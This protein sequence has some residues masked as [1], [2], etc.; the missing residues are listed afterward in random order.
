MKRSFRGQL[1]TRFA[2]AMVVAASAAALVGYLAL[3]AVLN[4]QIDASLLSVA[5]IQ[6]VS[7]TDDPTGQMRFQEWDLTPE[8]AESLRDLNRYAQVWN[9]SGVSLLR[10]RYMVS[11]LP[12]DHEL[13]AAASEGPVWREDEYEGQPIRA[14]YY[15]LS[16]QGAPHIEHVLEVAAPLAARDRTLQLV[17]YFLA[18]VV[19]IVGGGT[20]VGSWWL[21][22]STVRP[23]HEIIDQTEAIGAGT[24]GHHISAHADIREYERLVGVL[25]TMLDRIDEAFETQR[26]FTTDA[27]HELRS[28]LT[29]LRGELELALRR[30][31]SPDEYRRVLDSALEEAERLSDMA[32]NLLTLARSDAGAI[33]PR[34][35]QVDLCERVASVVERLQPRA[36]ARD[37]ALTVASEGPLR[38]VGDGALL[39]RLAWNLTDNA[40]KFAPPGG[41]VEVALTT[42]NGNAVITVSDDGPGI[43]PEDLQRVFERFYRSPESVD[44]G[45]SGLGLAIVRAI[46]RAHG[47]QARVENLA[48]GGAAFTVLLPRSGPQ[49][50]A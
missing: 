33:K 27:S 36:T 21:G 42:R 45:G 30:E 50:E 48:E 41:R 29:A 6:A 38:M 49:V 2:V 8:E 3:R 15:P 7:V 26:R 47:G 18:A 34:L 39:D 37:V 13:L 4:R 24:L 19:I 28:P 22:A 10:S 35:A 17:R 16:R 40:L 46:A 12:L 25:N 20:F 5:S 23:V 32:E 14:L 1:A 31:R 43:P 44:P 11:D 9:E